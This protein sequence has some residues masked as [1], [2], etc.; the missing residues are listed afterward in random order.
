MIAKL[1]KK[2]IVAFSY[3]TILSIIAVV[4][5]F[6][7]IPSPGKEQ[8]IA[9][10]AKR[11]A[12]LSNIQTAVDNY[13]QTHNTLPSTLDNLKTQAYDPSTPLVKTD[14][15]TKQPYEY[16]VTSTYSYKLCATFETDSTKDQP[17]PNDS[18]TYPVYGGDFTHPQGHFCFTEREQ[19]PYNQTYPV[20]HPSIFP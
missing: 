2:D 8:V 16:S 4:Y 5:A 6:S 14:P 7:I 12:D 11:V 3:I 15:Q 1:S 17:D 13:Y 10:D 19:P 9:R 18:T 20:T